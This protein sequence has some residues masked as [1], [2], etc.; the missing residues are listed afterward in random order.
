[1]IRRT[2]L[3]LDVRDDQ[4]RAVALR[5]KGRGSLLAGARTL[6][7][8][9][10]ALVP[11]AREANIRDL[12]AFAEGLHELLGPLAGGEERL[13]LSLPDTAGTLLLTEAESPFKSKGEGLDVLRWQLKGALPLDPREMHLDYQVLGRGESGRCRLVVAAV[14]RPVLQQYE[15]VLAG[16]G[17]NAAVVDFHCLNLYN[18]YRP[19]LDLGEDFSLVA[20]EGGGLTFQ[21]FQ[22]RELVFHRSCRVGA[23]PAQVFR[24]L[25][26]SL[27]ACRQK[28]AG[29]PRAKLFAH[30]DWRQSAS[31]TEP[32]QGLFERE[33]I[34]LDP[35]LERL[36]GGQLD[37]PSHQVRGLAAAV[38]AAERMM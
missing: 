17:F 25:N 9:E 38:G 1:M 12:R 21:F 30:S 13:S 28:Y 11:S 15:E 26:R 32:L 22:G 27:V 36:A 18:Y 19:R 20:V 2:Y 35:H 23:E 34:F 37:L 14:A 10:G 33:A 31:L 3:G 6:A 4:L 5:R 7:L 24:E 29:V 8:K 16:A